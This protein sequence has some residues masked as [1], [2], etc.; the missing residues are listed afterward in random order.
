LET[1]VKSTLETTYLQVREVLKRHRSARNN[2]WR[3]LDIFREYYGE[4]SSPLS[5]TRCRQKIQ[6][7]DLDYLPDP[8]VRRGRIAKQEKMEEFAKA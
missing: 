8:V 1:S 2:D 7:K 3:L 6:N 4:S 5:V